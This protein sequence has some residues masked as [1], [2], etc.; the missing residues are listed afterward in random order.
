[1]T[2]DEKTALFWELAQ[3]FIDNGA[4]RSTMMG[5]P[6]VRTEAGEFFAFDFVSGAD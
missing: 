1:M 2:N 5:F 3:P 4:E 6:C